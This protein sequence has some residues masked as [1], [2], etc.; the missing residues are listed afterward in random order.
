[1]PQRR[2]LRQGRTHCWG[3]G[4]GES[5]ASSSV[6]GTTAPAIALADTVPAMALADTVPE[7]ALAGTVP[8][9]ALADTMPNLQ[10]AAS[11]SE[12]TGTQL[13]PGSGPPYPVPENFWQAGINDWQNY[14]NQTAENLRNA[15]QQLDQSLNQGG[16]FYDSNPSYVNWQ[17]AND[18]NY[19]AN[20]GY[21]DFRF[22]NPL[23]QPPGGFTGNFPLPP[24]ET[25]IGQ[26]G[27]AD[28]LAKT[29]DAPPPP[30]DPA[31]EEA[32]RAK[33]RLRFPGLPL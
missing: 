29:A 21:Q 9:M 23:S 26:T 18:A 3:W 31:A 16:T 10:A 20:L 4:P 17:E 27:N 1:M 6:R 19:N 32:A 14:V 15:E 12:T 2:M 30:P 7:A 5:G 22:G 28:P 25:V 13:V 8:A 11:A 33:L 24:Q